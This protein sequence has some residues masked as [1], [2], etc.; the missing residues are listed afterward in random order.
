MGLDARV[1]SK[2]G[3]SDKKKQLLDDVCP[4]W[5]KFTESRP[6]GTNIH[7]VEWNTLMRYWS[8]AYMRGGWPEISHIIEAMRAVFG[9]VHYETDCDD[10]NFIEF[11]IEDSHKFWE[12]WRNTITEGAK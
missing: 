5:A 7:I 12:H 6:Y 4:S 1:Y 8:P 11:T 2:G 3:L 9:N 10:H